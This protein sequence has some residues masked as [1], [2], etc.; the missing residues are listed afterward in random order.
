MRA[1]MAKTRDDQWTKPDS[2]WCAKIAQRDQAMAM[3][4]G[5]S[6]SGVEKAYVAAVASRKNLGRRVG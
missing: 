1:R 6:P 4:A 3:E 5:R 2:V